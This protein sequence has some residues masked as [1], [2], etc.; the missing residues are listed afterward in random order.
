[1]KCSNESL[2]EAWHQFQEPGRAAPE[3]SQVNTGELSKCLLPVL[4]LGNKGKLYYKHV[5]NT[6]LL[7]I[8]T[9]LSCSPFPQVHTVHS[10]DGN[11][12]FNTVIL[13]SSSMETIA[14]VSSLDNGLGNLWYRSLLTDK[15]FW[16]S[17]TLHSIALFPSLCQH[18]CTLPPTP[19][20][21]LPARY[22]KM[23]WNSSTSCSDSGGTNTLS[24]RSS[25][26]FGPIGPQRRTQ[27]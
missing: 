8:K 19:L 20:H 23:R 4:A 14:N 15:D 5:L 3:K 7:L 21:S 10:A 24:S 16:H 13:L 6:F 18:S 12:V 25:C 2:P 11:T 27:R 1:M 26:S 22:S 17:H 9:D